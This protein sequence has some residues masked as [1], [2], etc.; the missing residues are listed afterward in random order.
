VGLTPQGYFLLA[1]LEGEPSGREEHLAR[2]VIRAWHAAE[3]DSRTLKF[4]NKIQYDTELPPNDKSIARKSRN[5]YLA[6]HTSYFL[7]AADDVSLTDLGYYMLGR[8]K[9]D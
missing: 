3:Q 1:L 2:N 7:E 5:M 8:H 9:P 4:L 6:R